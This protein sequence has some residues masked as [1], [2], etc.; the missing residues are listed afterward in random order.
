MRR[1]LVAA[2]GIALLSISCAGAIVGTRAAAHV[3]G[4]SERVDSTLA[5]S[6]GGVLLIASYR[7]PLRLGS[8]DTV[9]VCAAPGMPL[10]GAEV[11]ATFCRQ[12]DGRCAAYVRIDD[13]KALPV[14]AS[15]RA[16]SPPRILELG[17]SC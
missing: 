10:K 9:D 5:T 11:R 14:L 1:G 7:R 12:E 8:G 6:G 4:R 3:A 16:E 17:Q 13:A 15:Y 2:V